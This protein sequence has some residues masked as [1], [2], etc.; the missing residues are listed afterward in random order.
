LTYPPEDRDALAKRTE[1][2]LG[3]VANIEKSLQTTLEKFPGKLYTL[4]AKTHSFSKVDEPT[5]IIPL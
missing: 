2:A 1:Q 5:F 4:D 3:V